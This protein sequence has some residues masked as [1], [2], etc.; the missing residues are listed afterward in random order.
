M[1]LVIYCIINKVELS[2]TMAAGAG[3]KS[4]IL[5][6]HTLRTSV[7]C[8]ALRKHQKSKTQKVCTLLLLNIP[9]FCILRTNVMFWAECSLLFSSSTTDGRQ[10]EAVCI[11]KYYKWMVIYVYKTN[12]MESHAFL[13]TFE[14]LFCDPITPT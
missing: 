5:S 2:Y 3:R 8:C 13:T 7:C 6:Q 9:E 10:A 14:L 11:G 1:L 4:L 12:V